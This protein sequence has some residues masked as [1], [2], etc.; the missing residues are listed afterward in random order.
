MSEVKY[1]VEPWD[2]GDKITFAFIGD[3]Q[4]FFEENFDLMQKRK[5]K[6]KVIGLTIYIWP[7]DKSF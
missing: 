3:L 1:I 5:Q 4:K 6:S 2:K 7:S